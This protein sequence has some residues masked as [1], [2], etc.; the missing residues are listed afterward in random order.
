ME[1]YRTAPSFVITATTRPA[2]TLGIFTLAPTATTWR[3]CGGEEDRQLGR[4]TAPA[5]TQIEDREE[6]V[7]GLQN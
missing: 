1:K 3:T 5:P 6:S 7:Q 4:R 2:A